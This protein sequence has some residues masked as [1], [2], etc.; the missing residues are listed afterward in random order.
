[1]Q[2]TARNVGAGE[3]RERL[4]PSLWTLVSAAVAAPMAAL[5]FTPIDTTVA[6][7][8]GAAVGVGIIALLIAGSPVVE[9]RDGVLRA[10]RAH[11]DVSLLGE[12]TVHTADDARHARGAGLDPRSWHLIRGGIDGVVVVPVTDLDD[13]AP[14]WVISSRTPD[15]LAAAMRRAGATRRTPSR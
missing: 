4:G 1:M 10:G 3:Y 13:P 2:K 5:V 8:I 12:P 15:R 6:L 14:T 11:I 7:V 9:L